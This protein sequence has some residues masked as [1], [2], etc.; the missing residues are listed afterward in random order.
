MSPYTPRT[1]LVR[2][3]RCNVFITTVDSQV[4]GVKEAGVMWP[5]ISCVITMERWNLCTVISLMN[6]SVCELVKK[7]FTRNSQRMNP[8]AQCI[9]GA[10]ETSKHS[11]FFLPWRCISHNTFG[12]NL[13]TIHLVSHITTSIKEKWWNDVWIQTK[14]N[15]MLCWSS[16][17]MGVFSFR[18]HSD[19]TPFTGTKIN[20]H[21]I[22]DA[23]WHH[24]VICT[25]KSH[26]TFEFSSILPDYFVHKT[27]KNPRRMC[28][29]PR[30]A[31]MMTH[32]HYHATSDG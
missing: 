8:Y 3:L 10:L 17:Q 18:T 5:T 15:E 2:S 4:A 19:F 20:K 16:C 11:Q 22:L 12:R 30:E 26:R 13:K 28:W 21:P 29:N 14:Q 7:I 25:S 9:Y 1:P 31:G 24:Q 6:L 27:N 23:F 32:S